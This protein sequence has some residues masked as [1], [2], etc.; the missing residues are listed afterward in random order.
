[1]TK[2]DSEMSDDILEP[3]C[4]VYHPTGRVSKFIGTRKEDGYIITQDVELG[5]E[6]TPPGHVKRVPH[7]NEQ[8]APGT[9]K[10]PPPAL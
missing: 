9:K 3:G 7:N 4:N 1:M 10:K 2:C 8:Q 6:F 5:I